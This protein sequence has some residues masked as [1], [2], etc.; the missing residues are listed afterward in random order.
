MQNPGIAHWEGVKHVI[1]YLGS[2]KD[3]WLTFGGTKRNVAE[4]FCNADWA[5]QKDCHSISGF[6]FQYGSSAISWSSKKQS[7]IALSSM[8][9]EYVAKTNAAK[10][11][12]W[13][14]SFINK[15]TGIN[16]WPLT[17]RSNNQGAMA[18]AKDNKFHSCTK[19]I[20]LRYHFICEAVKDG[21]IKLSYVPTAKNVADIFM[22][23][24]AKPKFS[25]F[26]TKL[27]L[28]ERTEWRSEDSCSI[29][30]GTTKDYLGKSHDECICLL[31][32]K[33]KFPLEGECWIFIWVGLVCPSLPIFWFL[34]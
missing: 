3:F 25:E 2:T 4:P 10:E 33:H 8:E 23:T 1:S 21:K 16:Y 13:L 32:D 22:K 17:I 19:H 34:C 26:M 24:M 29:D 18:L 30:T 28:G 20:D 27:G 14:Q 5:S 9:V 7:I 15:V 6:C 11:A 31:T 12:L